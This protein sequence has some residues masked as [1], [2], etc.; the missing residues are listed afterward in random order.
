MSFLASNSYFIYGLLCIS[1]IFLFSGVRLVIQGIST[2]PL[3]ET[4]L[5]AKRIKAIRYKKFGK[6][7]NVSVWSKGAVFLLTII[8]LPISIYFLFRSSF[9]NLKGGEI[10]E[11]SL[12]FLK[13]FVAQ[14]DIREIV[15][16][17]C[18]IYFLIGCFVV[19]MM[20]A[21]KAKIKNKES[22]GVRI[23]AMSLAFF[24]VANAV[25]IFLT[26]SQ[27][28]MPASVVYLIPISDVF[29][30]FYELIYYFKSGNLLNLYD[31][32]SYYFL[33]VFD[34]FLFL[35]IIVGILC[36]RRWAYYLLMLVSLIFIT[37]AITFVVSSAGMYPY[38]T[39]KNCVYLVYF[40]ILFM[41]FN[42]PDVKE[43]FSPQ[44]QQKDIF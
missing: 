7:K 32:Q 17:N 4:V 9:I 1:S 38:H 20:R 28:E 30:R 24:P 31:L 42:H 11:S 39:I 13:H 22:R 16:V 10:V 2:P 37:N 34:N 21:V 29:G 15:T 27:I 25:F 18:L 8:G 19:Q 6:D 41:F 3:R 44:F 43:Q 40:T 5:R 23:L 14:F 12:Y 26:E 35:I 33:N 36:L